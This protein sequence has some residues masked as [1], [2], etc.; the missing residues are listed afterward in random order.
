[1]IPSTTELTVESGRAG[2]PAIDDQKDGERALMRRIT[3]RLVP[4]IVVLY[5][6]AYIDR[7]N[8]GYA[9]LQMLGSLHISEAVYGFGASLFFIGYLLFEVPSNIALH[10]FGA[11]RWIARIMLTWGIVTVAMAWTSS[12]A[13]FWVLRF[14]LG[15]AEAGL[16]PGVIFYVTLWFP[17]RYRMRVLGI[18]TLGSSAGNMIGSLI[19]GVFLDLD[20]MAG[21]QG[22]QWVFIATGLPA[23][24]L[25]FVT[26]AYL[27]DRPATAKFLSPADRELLGSLLAAE[28]RQT[29]THPNPLTLLR[30]WRL[31]AFA[32]VYM[33]ISMSTYGVAYWLPT[34]VR[35]FGVS[36]TVNGLLNMIPWFAACVVLAWV[37]GRLT[38]TGRVINAALVASVIG[39]ACFLLAACAGSNVLRLAAL[40]VGAP[41][42]YILIPCFWSLPSRLLQGVAAAVG[43]AAINSVGNIGGFIAQ[44]AM[45]WVGGITHSALTPMLVPCACLIAL[46]I[47][48]ALVSRTAGFT[49][50][51]AQSAPSTA[52]GH[53][54]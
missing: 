15:A 8:V 54:A 46:F 45:P 37:P 40:T 49:R 52:K 19:G 4:M 22:W 38:D 10:R 30:D 20:G 33:L 31:A 53:I 3:W 36:G 50:A 43:I 12:A 21:L 5:L 16:Y 42:I 41:C 23:I 11:R 6:V 51:L 25:T 18:F 1:M 28:T 7:Q 24:A 27:P 17:A 35:G 29:L 44:N 47:T 39:T 48:T 9:K 2:L 32:L 34:V 26:L 14:L 13:M